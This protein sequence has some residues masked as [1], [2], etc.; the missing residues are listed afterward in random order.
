LL[1]KQNRPSGP[2]LPVIDP[3]EINANRRIAVRCVLVFLFIRFGFLHELIR[4]KTGV[5]TYMVLISAL[6]TIPAVILGGGL[7][8]TFSAGAARVWFVF[9]GWLLIDTIFSQWIT[10]SAHAVSGYV[11]TV[12]PMVLVTAGVVLT[13]KEFAS[14]MYAFGFASLSNI[15][16][17]RFFGSQNS[18]RENLGVGTIAN[19]NDFGA[20]LI[21]ILP[22]LLFAILTVRSKTIK[23]IATGLF[24]YGLYLGAKT[25]SRGAL[26]A[27]GFVLVFILLR[28]PARV[29]IAVLVG[30]PLLSAVLI[31]VLPSYITARY[32]TLFNSDSATAPE[33]AVQ[34]AAARKEL[35]WKGVQMT[36]EHPLTGVGVEQF[37]IANGA[38]LVAKGIHAEW[39]VAHNTYTQLSGET[40][41]PGFLIY[42][43]GM[44][45]AFLLM[46]SSVKL[47]RGR[48]DLKVAG[49]AGFCLMMSL[50]GFGTASFFISQ[51]YSFYMP[52]LAG[53][54]VALN[55]VVRRQIAAQAQLQPPVP[56]FQPMR[57]AVARRA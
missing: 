21:F 32:G 26:L 15:L 56:G 1:N 19:A 41:V 2:A 28:A 13:M 18:E 30:V 25:G 8:R 24:I 42:V 40:G 44:V 34:S 36:M 54:A 27:I 31:A 20:H 11:Q 7:R 51:A 43:I 38:G 23:T 33:E 3:E 37:Q 57:P 52:T 14:M 45:S 47:C 48:P 50:L 46:N 5:N 35:F 17:A 49:T 29:R 16:T 53:V 55:R 4:A 39:Q 22:F 6:I 12:T 10:G 9:A